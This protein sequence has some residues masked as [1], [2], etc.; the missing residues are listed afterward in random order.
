MMLRVHLSLVIRAT[1][2]GFHYDVVEL[3]SF[4]WAYISLR[5]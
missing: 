4:V 5:P 1:L 3:V 2:S